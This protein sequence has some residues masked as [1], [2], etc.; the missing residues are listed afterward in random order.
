MCRKSPQ[1][2]L[3]SAPPAGWPKVVLCMLP[4]TFYRRGIALVDR[5]GL[6]SW[7]RREALPFRVEELSQCQ[8][9]G[10][11]GRSCIGHA[12]SSRSREHESGGFAGALPGARRRALPLRRPRR[13]D[14]G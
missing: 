12:G 11:G 7:M 1:C 9:L 3:I 13:G 10:D 6:L 14:D 5:T 2:A 4:A 8:E